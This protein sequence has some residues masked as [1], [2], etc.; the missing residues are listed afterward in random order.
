M[1]CQSF[2]ARGVTV[3]D[4]AEC[5]VPVGKCVRSCRYAR[6]SAGDYGDFAVVVIVV[7]SCGTVIVPCVCVCV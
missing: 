7:C 2:V 6:F 3:R 5:N 4:T 1:L